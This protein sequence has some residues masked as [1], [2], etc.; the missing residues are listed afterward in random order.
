MRI[1][2]AGEVPGG[3]DEGVERVGLA[4][5][6]AAAVGAGDVLPGRVAGERIARLAEVEVSGRRTGRSLSGTA[7][8][9][10]VGTVDHRDRTAPAALAGDAPVAQAK[11]DR[12]LALALRLDAGDR[13]GLG[14]LDLQA[15]QEVRS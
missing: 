4:L 6:R 3:I 13:G 11:D 10:Q 15:V 8:T 14:R 5:G 9:P 1:G 12:A 2:E 7:T